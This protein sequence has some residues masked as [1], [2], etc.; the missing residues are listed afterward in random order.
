M[1]LLTSHLPTSHAVSLL[2]VSVTATLTLTLTRHTSHT[3]ATSRARIKVGE[4]DESLHKFGVA[5]ACRVIEPR[6]AHELLRRHTLAG[7]FLQ[8]P[9]DHVLPFLGYLAPTLFVK[10]QRLPK[11]ALWEGE[12]TSEEEMHHHA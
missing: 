7:L 10:A 6:M 2:T 3:S 8:Q 9:P 1:H 4:R 11:L 5:N 12:G